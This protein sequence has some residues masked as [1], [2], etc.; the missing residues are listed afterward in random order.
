[1]KKTALLLALWLAFLTFPA[2]AETIAY[3]VTGAE[4]NLSADWIVM[5][6]EDSQGLDEARDMFLENEKLQLLCTSQKDIYLLCLYVNES[7][8]ISDF[9]TM[10]DKAL[11]TLATTIENR[12]LEQNADSKI[13]NGLEI[14][15][16]RQTNF[17]YSSMTHGTGDS[18]MTTL[19]LMT[20]EGGVFYTLQMD[21]LSDGSN[22]KFQADFMEIMDG[23]VFDGDKHNE[24]GEAVPKPR[25]S[26]KKNDSN[27]LKTVT[28]QEDAYTVTMMMPSVWEETPLE[29]DMDG[30]DKRY[31]DGG[32]SMN[33][34]ISDFWEI[35]ES[36]EQSSA[37]YDRTI[38]DL[39]G[40][41]MVGMGL[42]ELILGE[43]I[44]TTSN[45]EEAQDISSHNYLV[46]THTA[47][48]DKSSAD[49]LNFMAYAFIEDGYCFY[50]QFA[51]TEDLA[52]WQDTAHAVIA[53]IE[54]LQQ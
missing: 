40:R 1:M 6:R 41:D 24:G 19:T 35:L 43:G 34:G 14:I 37:G 4:L 20:V 53:S 21:A 15:R 42:A 16:H 10:D 49:S 45:H 46:F 44:P 5:T 7:S 9:S 50:Y 38:C 33:F 29:L 52:L 31:S 22:E 3:H 47:S 27:D 48:K 30:F 18:A 23:M 17:L 25:Q 54:Y 32:I 2:A 28:Y 13:K 36:D 8:D 26:S 12:V 51:S 39:Y 11:S